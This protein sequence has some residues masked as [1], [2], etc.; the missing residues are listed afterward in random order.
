MCINRL[1]TVLAGELSRI[2]FVL[3]IGVVLPYDNGSTHV[4]RGYNI[5]EIVFV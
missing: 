5:K 2:Y 3:P 4:P 1:G